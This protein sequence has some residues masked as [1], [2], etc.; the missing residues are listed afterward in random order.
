M[1]LNAL[2]KNGPVLTTDK[3]GKR[4]LTHITG[5]KITR[6]TLLCMKI[7]AFILFAFCMHVGAA[8]L[9]QNVTLSEHKAPLEKVINEIKR[10][11][12][13]S[14]FYNQDWLQQ[15]QP[16]DVQ[17]KNAPLETVLKTCFSNQPFDYAIVNKTIVLKLKEKPVEK[18]EAAVPVTVTGRITDTLGTPLIGATILLKG[19]KNATITNENGEFS[20]VAQTGDVLVVSYIGYRN[21]EISVGSR[22]PQLSNLQLYPLIS[23]L[24][25]VVVSNGYQ[26]LPL[27]RSAGSYD[28]IDNKL[29]NREVSPDVISRLQGIANSVYFDQRNG[30]NQ[31]SIRGYSTFSNYSDK[32]S[33]LIVVDN[34]PYDGLITNIN[35]NDVESITVLKDAAAASI[36]GARAGNG[37]IVITTKKGQKNRPVSVEVN[38]NVTISEKPHL[39]DDRNFINSSAFIDV[40]KFLYS[41]GYYD[42]IVNDTYY[43][44]PVS[45]VVA[46]LDSASKGLVSQSY[47]NKIIDGYRNNDI[48][49]DLLKYFYQN[50]IYQQY[51]INLSGGTDKTS[52]FFS[53]GD[54]H[55]ALSQVKNTNQRYTINSSISY[56]PIRNLEIVG[57]INYVQ[58][59]NSSDNTV[60]NIFTGGQFSGIYPYAKL[61]DN[62]ENPLPIVKDYATSF[63]QEA[64]QHGFLNWQFYPLQELRNG[65]NTSLYNS[66]DTRIN[67]EANYTII[68]GLIARGQY[69]YEKG[70]NDYN[71]LATVDSYSTRNLINQYSAVNGD[72]FVSYVWPLGGLKNYGE[73][74]LTSKSSRGSLHYNKIWG[75][76][77]ISALAGFEARETR[78]DNNSNALP[79]L[80]E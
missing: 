6:Q 30:Q 11:T 52:Y 53:A 70:I 63:V 41:K 77:A 40:E 61:A 65:Y 62:N 5:I 44:P 46:L 55:D 48:R 26:A 10:Q 66:Y 73:S 43:H 33:P 67:L 16:V 7:T 57:S 13:Y 36:W 23:G 49:K 60:N 24:K 28:H 54:D 20:F 3:P 18:K 19:T 78:N 8:T 58:S 22:N 4:L 37:V 80:F 68:P 74:I 50:P 72:E 32:L 1:Q 75:P 76:H 2:C 21:A 69:Q 64:P 34:F 56:N 25:E 51:S 27:E 12:G 14:F 38:S 9:A 42:N 47:A 45:P 15:A 29:F 71:Q 31:I 35:P 59:Q 17:V 79:T 39:Y